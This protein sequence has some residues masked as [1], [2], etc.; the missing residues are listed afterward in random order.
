M[1][2]HVEKS[3]ECPETHPWACVNSDS[4][5]VMGCHATK[6]EAEAQMTSLMGKSAPSGERHHKA[7]RSVFPMS[8]LRLEEPSDDGRRRIAGYAAVFGN[9]D[10]YGDII[11]PG[12]F[13]RTLREKPD[14]KVLWQ[15]STREP[16]GKQESGVEDEFGLDVVGVLSNIPKVKDEVVPLMLD[17]VVTGLSIGYDVVVEEYNAELEAW[18]LKDIDLWEWSPVTFPANELATVSEVKN[19]GGRDDE[20]V[21]RVNRHSKALIHELEGYFAKSDRRGVLPSEQI[22][23]LHAL[24]GGKLPGAEAVNAKLIELAYMR[25]A[26]DLL[27]ALGSPPIEKE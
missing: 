26:N 2:Y 16:I 7:R 5:M 27:E 10:A 3:D 21:A 20:H 4:G 19:L 25:G 6:A 22:A 9:R 18:F 15:H 14:V 11:M 1:K 13:E 23:T 12:A 8:R 24:L 17:G